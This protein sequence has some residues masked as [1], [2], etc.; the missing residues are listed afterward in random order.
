MLL[1]VL[2]SLQPSHDVGE[3]ASRQDLAD[4]QNGENIRDFLYSIRAV[5]IT[6]LKLEEKLLNVLS[7]MQAYKIGK[8][9]FL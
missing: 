4:N 3:L 1:F 5:H 2:T 8:F 7:C 6:F 9:L